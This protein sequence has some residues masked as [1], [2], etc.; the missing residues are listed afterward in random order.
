MAFVVLV[1]PRPVAFVTLRSV[2]EGVTV[3]IDDDSL[4]MTQQ[5]PQTM[6]FVVLISDRDVVIIEVDNNNNTWNF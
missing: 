6:H 2:V 5:S 3:Y 1:R 4:V